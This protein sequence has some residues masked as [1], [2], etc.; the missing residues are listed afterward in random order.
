MVS[1]TTPDILGGITGAKDGSAL[2]AG[3][4]A[5]SW[6]N[7][8]NGSVNVLVASGALGHYFD[9]AIIPELR[10]KLDS[11]K[12]VRKISDKHTKW[13]VIYLQSL[14]STS[15]L[16]SVIRAVVGDPWFPR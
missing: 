14:R 15:Q 1:K 4:I 10:E 13:T 5:G 8:S 6:N 11:Y 12:Y 2:T 16:V 7:E 9:D 3:L